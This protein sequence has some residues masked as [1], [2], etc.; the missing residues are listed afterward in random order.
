V[1]VSANATPAVTS[2][3]PSSVPQGSIQ[4]DIYL[5]GKGFFSTSTVVLNGAP[6]ASVT[7]T[8][9]NTTLLR[10]RIT[11]PALSAAAI[12]T[13]SVQSQSGDLSAATNLNVYAVKPALLS[14]PP[15]T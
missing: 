10:A 1:D 2:V 8:Y 5:I 12:L 13:L 15:N 14:L 7:T 11:A 9:L 4:Q 6:S 3:V